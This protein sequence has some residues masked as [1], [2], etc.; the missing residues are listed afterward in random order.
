MR[1][2]A[3]KKILVAYYSKT[4]TTERVAKDIAAKLNADV[5]KIVDKK[6]RS[7]ILGWFIG[8]K[9][10]SKRT[11]EIGVPS[12]DAAKYDITVIGTPVWAWNMT[13]EV[14]TYIE[15]NKNKLKNVAFFTTSE[16]TKPYEIIRYMQ[17][18]SEKTAAA[19]IGF[20]IKEI[21]DVVVYSQKLSAFVSAIMDHSK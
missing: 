9:D 7:G 2:Q 12:K 1:M 20:A 17:E 4:G 8:G 3:D 6:S 21:K 18:A 19:A 10:A 14:R 11:T 15:Q 16:N 13:P 5:E